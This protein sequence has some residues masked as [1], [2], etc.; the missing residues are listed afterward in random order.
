[1]DGKFKISLVGFLIIIFLGGCAQISEMSKTTKG[2]ALGGLGGATAG[3]IIGGQVG[4]PVAGAA[5][6]G[7]LGALGGGAVGRSLEKQDQA[8]AEQQA[9]L[10]QQ[11]SDIE[12]NRALIEELKKSN[13]EARETSR[14]VAVNLPSVLF[15]LGS[16]DLSSSGAEKVGRI[17]AILEREAADRRVS[18]EGHA[19]RERADQEDFN[20]RLSER[21][22]R[23]V[24]DGL[25]ERGVRR[26]RVTAR[27]FGTRFP[28]ASNQ[29]EEERQKN[30]RVEV[31]IEN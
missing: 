25:E 10:D 13:I 12:R 18:V 11:R 31:I 23:R 28:V 20:Q 8:Q 30:R 9:K 7:T 22:A 17:A 5:I 6:G 24:A 14:G 16:A 2:A 4:H 29:T 15:R 26:D 1:M 27:G 21:R 19:S 3:G